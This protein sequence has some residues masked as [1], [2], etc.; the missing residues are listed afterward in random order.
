MSYLFCAFVYDRKAFDPRVIVELLNE[1]Y[2]PEDKH[3]A[4]IK[5][6][7]KGTIDAIFML[8]LRK[9][10]L[11]SAAFFDRV[12]FLEDDFVQVLYE[13]VSEGRGAVSSRVPPVVYVVAY[14]DMS[15]QNLLWKISPAGMDYR[16]VIE[17]E[18]YHIWMPA[19]GDPVD[20]HEDI[21]V[22]PAD[23]GATEESDK[24]FRED[25]YHAEV[26]RKERPFSPK[27]VLHE[28]LRLKTSRLLDAIE[29]LEQGEKV[30]PEARKAAVKKAPAGKKKVAATKK[31]APAAKNIAGAKKIPPAKKNVA[32]AKKVSAAK[33]KSPATKRT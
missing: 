1:N 10:G 29:R 20:R 25:E 7:V 24:D 3:D 23:F 8:P 21:S 30:W 6:P 32:A 11:K 27:A 13:A 9:N 26:A 4:L 5:V 22:D 19:G 14:C 28:E 18:G 16:A 33:T 12:E 2:K 17:D 15:P 31:T